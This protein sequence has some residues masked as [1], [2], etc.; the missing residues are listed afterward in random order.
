M[1]A[2][3]LPYFEL[4]WSTPIFSVNSGVTNPLFQELLQAACE[5]LDV[6]YPTN[7]RLHLMVLALAKGWRA[8]FGN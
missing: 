4:E 2:L 8:N 7:C 5:T 6:H 1:P 3:N